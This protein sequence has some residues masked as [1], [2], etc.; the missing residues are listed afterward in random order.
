MASWPS[1]SQV[2][3]G[4]TVSSSGLSTP[5]VGLAE[6]RTRNP[7]AQCPAAAEEEGCHQ[8]GNRMILRPGHREQSPRGVNRGEADEGGHQAAG[9]GVITVTS[10]FCSLCFLISLGQSHL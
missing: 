2:Q 7:I 9:F 1:L 5:V 6:A 8:V 4:D 10:R 3:A